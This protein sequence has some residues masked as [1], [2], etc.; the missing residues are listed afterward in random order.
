MG[1]LFRVLLLIGVIAKVWPVIVGVLV[2]AVLCVVLW[3]F[4]R[5]LDRRLDARDARRAARTA[6]LAADRSAG[7]SAARMGVGRRRPRYLRRMHAHAGTT[8]ENS[9]AAVK[10]IAKV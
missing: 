9:A 2:F 4:V 3:W 1:G 7:G 6:E 5:W 10:A 8:L